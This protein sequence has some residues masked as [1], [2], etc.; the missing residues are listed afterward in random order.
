VVSDCA[1]TLQGDEDGECGE[2][3]EEDDI[4]ASDLPDSRLDF[5]DGAD[6][7]D[8]SSAIAALRARLGHVQAAKGASRVTPSI[9]E[10]RD[11]LG[12]IEPPPGISLTEEQRKQLSDAWMSE[13]SSAAGDVELSLSPLVGDPNEGVDPTRHGGPPSQTDVLN[14]RLLASFKDSLDRVGAGYCPVMERGSSE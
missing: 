6:A 14:Q 10:L 9:A 4:R 12:Q 11:R 7:A 3:E 2:D 8:M 1:E 13:Q 5:G